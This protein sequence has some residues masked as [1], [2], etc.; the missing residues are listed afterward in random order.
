MSEYDE[1]IRM[2]LQN[3]FKSPVGVRENEVS[4][5]ANVACEPLMLDLVRQIQVL[6]IHDCQ[7]HNIDTIEIKPKESNFIYLYIID[8]KEKFIFTSNDKLYYEGGFY[9]V[10]E[11]QNSFGITQTPSVV[12]SEHDGVIMCWYN[13]ELKMYWDVGTAQWYCQPI[14]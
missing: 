8:K 10:Q 5:Y 9:T 4:I 13:K 1:L 7:E 12:Y 2:Q 11:L 3:R 14:V 6:Q